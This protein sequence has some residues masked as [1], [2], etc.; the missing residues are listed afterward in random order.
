MPQYEYVCDADGEVITLLRPMRDADAP[1][2]DP[3]GRGRRFSRRLSS[4]AVSGAGTAAGGSLPMGGCCPCGKS[5]GSCS[6]GFGGG[7]S[8]G[9]GN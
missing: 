7:S 2:E 5:A 1:V 9:S 3:T 4:F 8:A 6:S